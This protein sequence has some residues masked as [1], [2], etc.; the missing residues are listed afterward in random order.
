[1]GH[2]LLLVEEGA[3]IAYHDPHI[4]QLAKLGL[5]SVPLD[6][7]VLRD[8]DAV[9][10]VTAHSSVDWE[11]IAREAPLIVDFRNVVPEIDGKVWRL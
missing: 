3:Q 10:V 1:M 7:E 9:A 2:H 4:P 6:A 8:V 5:R 11:L